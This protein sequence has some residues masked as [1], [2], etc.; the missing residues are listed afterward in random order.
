MD[1]NLYNFLTNI[2][3]ENE[4]RIN[5]QPDKKWVILTDID[6]LKDSFA[7]TWDVYID[8]IDIFAQTSYSF[9]SET[10]TQEEIEQ[11]L[12]NLNT[13]KE[14][15]SLVFNTNNNKHFASFNI[16][17]S[18]LLKKLTEDENYK[19]KVLECRIPS[20]Q[21][22][23]DIPEH[24]I[25]VDF[26]KYNMPLVFD[27]NKLLKAKVSNPELTD[28]FNIIVNADNCPEVELPY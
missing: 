2:D 15:C 1:K 13:Q 7:K 4:K 25:Y 5:A 27:Y 8:H 18:S 12:E 6:T 17:L 21:N 22:L 11:A 10:P 26:N 19:N 3:S 14:T 23:S 9:K 16:S 28:L 20:S 24:N